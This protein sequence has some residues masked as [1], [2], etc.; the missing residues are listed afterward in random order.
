MACRKEGVGGGTVCG[1][2]F[3]GGTISECGVYAAGGVG[4][5]GCKET[6]R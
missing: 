1:S 3:I 4:N 5:V 2:L 6:R